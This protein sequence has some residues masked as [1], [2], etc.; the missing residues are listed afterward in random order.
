M[1]SVIFVSLGSSISSLQEVCI[2]HATHVSGGV[3]SSSQQLTPEPMFLI[4]QW[5][6]L[7]PVLTT[8]PPSFPYLSGSVSLAHMDGISGLP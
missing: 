2:I 3:K 5:T 8:N 1:C 4:T 7:K 6:P